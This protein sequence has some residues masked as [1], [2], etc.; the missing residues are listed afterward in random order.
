M[1]PLGDTNESSYTR[2][3]LPLIIRQGG[4]RSNVDEV[5]GMYQLAERMDIGEPML[6]KNRGEHMGVDEPRPKLGYDLRSGGTDTYR[7]TGCW[8][9]RTELRRIR[10][11]Q[12][13]KQPD[14]KMDAS[15]GRF[16]L[17]CGVRRT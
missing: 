4:N 16:E 11:R 15:P 12:T 10:K 7:F 5:L 3:S 9:R 8:S 6:L 17:S 1:E 14:M 13:E 2:S